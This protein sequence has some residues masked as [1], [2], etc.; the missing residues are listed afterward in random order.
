MRINTEHL[1]VN[2]MVKMGDMI[3]L[4]LN[5]ESFISIQPDIPLAQVKPRFHLDLELAT[6]D[7]LIDMMTKCNHKNDW[8]SLMLESMLKEKIIPSL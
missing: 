1:K 3:L 6:K 7:E 2:Q 5:Q 8:Y 4:K